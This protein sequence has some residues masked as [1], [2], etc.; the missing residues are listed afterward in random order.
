GVVARRAS[1][2]NR[3]HSEVIVEAL[4]VRDR[5]RSSIE[6]LLTARDRLACSR[7][8]VTTRQTCPRVEQREGLRSEGDPLRIRSRKRVDSE[9]RTLVSEGPWDRRGHHPYRAAPPHCLRSGRNR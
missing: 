7:L 2:F 8:R 1:P 5:E 9:V 6:D 4:D 3:G